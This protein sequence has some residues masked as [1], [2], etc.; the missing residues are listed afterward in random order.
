MKYQNADGVIVDITIVEGT[1]II[2]TI[3]GEQVGTE[4][5]SLDLKT[6]SLFS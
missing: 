1:M 2:N 5:Q 3:N 4:G 6:Q